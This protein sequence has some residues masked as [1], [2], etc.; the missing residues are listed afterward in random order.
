MA[1]GRL[2]HRREQRFERA[3]AEKDLCAVAVIRAWR[4]GRERGGGRSG[5]GH[6]AIGW[7]VRHAPAR[8]HDRAV[9]GAA[10][11]IAGERLM[12]EGVVRAFA[13]VVESEHRHHETRRAEAALGRI[14]VD[15]RLLH[16]MERAVRRRQTLDRQHGAI[17]DLRQHHQA[18]ID[19]AILHA[20][21]RHGR[22]STMVQAPQSPSA[23]PSLVPVRKARVRS[24]SSTVMVGG[25]LASLHGFPFNKNRTSVIAQGLSRA[26]RAATASMLCKARTTWQPPSRMVVPSHEGSTFAHFFSNKC[27]LGLGMIPVDAPGA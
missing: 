11:E 24:Q 8:L 17:V 16:R 3:R 20:S 5:L 22:P 1:S 25:A 19:G 10:A 27:R 6:E 12:N 2:R 21:R 26:V 4:Q 14:G 15:H 13:A 23:Q 9:A 7:P 18:G